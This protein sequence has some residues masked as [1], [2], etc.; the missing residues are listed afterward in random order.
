MARSKATWH[1]LELE[2]SE[3]EREVARFRI[4]QVLKV[5]KHDRHTLRAEKHANNKPVSKNGRN[6]K[7][8]QIY[9]SSSG[10]RAYG[11]YLV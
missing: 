10:F 2:A 11:L 4:V 5:L 3:F 9:R 1:M 6:C 7:Q 8:S